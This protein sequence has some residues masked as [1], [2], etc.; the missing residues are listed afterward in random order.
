[1]LFLMYNKTGWHSLGRSVGGIGVFLL[2]PCSRGRVELSS[3]DPTAF[4]RVRF[5]LLED[6]KDFARMVEGVRMALRALIEEEVLRLR[7]EVFAP[8]AAIGAQLAT[9][10]RWHGLIASLISFGLRLPPLRRAALRK[11]TLNVY[12]M[13]EDDRAVRDYVRE[14]AQAVYHVSGTCRMGIPRDPHAVVD[15]TCRVFGIG[16]LRVVDASVFPTI[17]R[18]QTHFPVLMTAE[19]IADAIKSACR[20]HDNEALPE[21]ST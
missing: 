6:D 1:M 19:K 7:N 18:G 9:R 12:S 2:K 5:N 10:T 14:S 3:A 8:N 4:P 17:P 15:S 11:S 20:R 21:V 16:G 13:L